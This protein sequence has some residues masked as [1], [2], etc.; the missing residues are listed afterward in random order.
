[1]YAMYLYSGGSSVN[2][3]SKTR[4]Q[5]SPQSQTAKFEQLAR[6]L[7]ADED[8]AHFEETLKKIAT[9]TP[10]KAEKPD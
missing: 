2:D 3:M 1:M 7:G 10:P 8:P 9:K 4:P 6:E 5:D